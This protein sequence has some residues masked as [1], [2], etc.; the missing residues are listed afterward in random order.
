M[1]FNSQN[2]YQ[3]PYS[4]AAD[5]N[6][7]I[8]ATPERFDSMSADIAEA[9][10]ELRQMLAGI[11]VTFNPLL[12]YSKEAVDSLL[13]DYQPKLIS[14]PLSASSIG[15]TIPPLTDGRI[16]IEF[17]PLSLSGNLGGIQSFNG[18]SDPN[19]S[20][21]Q[22]DIIN[23]LGYSPDTPGS[24]RSIA[25][26]TGL[27]SA[28]D[29]KQ[30]VLG[31]TPV[32]GAVLAQPNGVAT[33]GSDGKLL[34]SQR[35]A[36]VPSI[37]DVTGLTTALSDINSSLSSKASFSQSTNPMGLDF[38]IGQMLLVDTT[39]VTVNKRQQRTVYVGIDNDDSY[40]LAG[41]GA[42][43]LGSWACCGVVGTSGYFQRVS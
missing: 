13:D 34:E 35:V 12:Y 8:A 27:Q 5:K 36:T 20:L 28:L 29:S 41:S 37:G 16:P 26:V 33:L 1:P 17:L 14:V 40:N 24:P 32:D 30:I 25:Q 39:S 4:F 43:L 6:T 3:L 15:V 10:T 23:A 19:I 11:N 18:R 21:I 9:M 42:A 22:D 7:G 31:F 38:P 2:V